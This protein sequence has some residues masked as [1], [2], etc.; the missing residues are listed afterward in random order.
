MNLKS[1]KTLIMG[2]AAV[3][4]LS[5]HLL[6]LPR[7]Q[8]IYSTLLRF[9][10][11]TAYVG[12][13]IFFFMSGYM[14]VYSDTSDYFIYVKR[15]F[16]RI[17]PMF[18]LFGIIAILL[19]RLELEKS[20]L[21]FTGLD[22]FIR[23]GGSFLW[24]IPSLIIFYL[25]VPLYL[26]LVRKFGNWTVFFITI[27]SWAFIM[28]LFEKWLPLQAANIFL[29]RI[30]VILLGISLAK[31]EGKWQER[32]KLIAAILLLALGLVVTWNFGFRAKLGFPISD[33]F[34]VTAL[35]H[36]I[37]TVLLFD[38]LFSYKK[39]RI[40][41]FI[42]GISLELYCVQMVFGSLLFE[43]AVSYTKNAMLS[44]VITCLLVFVLSYTTKKL[45]IIKHKKSI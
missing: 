5:Y 40:F 35:P 14:S 9:F 10:V 37:G 18:I 27:I 8:D 28:L 33:I 24:F 26:R 6:P 25:T 36:V 23:G 43:Y 20:W 4:I 7:T 3:L 22:L 11:T 2:W 19:G 12:V 44:F 1:T 41:E 45:N 15:K 17:Y 39:S 42:G 38:V 21:T 31:Y 32:S 30:P 13:D 29:C 16:L 34:Y